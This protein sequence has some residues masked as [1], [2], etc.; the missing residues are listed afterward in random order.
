MKVSELR[1]LIDSDI[2]VYRCGF[3]CK[4]DEPVENALH[5]VKLIL[6]GILETFRNA[7]S[8]QLYLTG[9]GNFRDEIATI[10]EYKGSRKDKPKPKYY[11]EIRDYLTGRWDATVI[12]GMEADD[13]LGI[14]QWANKDKS[15]VIVSI[16]KDLDMIPGYHY[17]FVKNHVYYVRLWDANLNFWR[18]VLTGDRT[19]DIPGI[20]GMGPKTAE[21]LLADVTNLAEARAIVEKEYHKAFGPGWAP[22]MEENAD[23]LWIRRTMDTTWRDFA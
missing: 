16:D 18:Q 2:I 23:L 22:I 20:K 14:E 21:K 19:D 10:Q 9:K 3:A 12:D 7:P 4:D 15:T 1:P 11:Q 13:A 17:N 5:S 6:N 8:H